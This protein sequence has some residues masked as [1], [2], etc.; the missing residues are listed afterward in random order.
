M[1]LKYFDVNIRYHSRINSKSS[2][3]LS[4]VIQQTI[5]AWGYVYLLGSFMFLIFA[6]VWQIFGSSEVQPWDSYWV[7]EKNVDYTCIEDNSE[8]DEETL[9]NDEDIF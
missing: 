8:D 3:A 9:E 4:I 5:L 7:C 2:N 6:M 1:N